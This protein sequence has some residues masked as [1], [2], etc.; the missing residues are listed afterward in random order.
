M[1]CPS[2]R[3]II[4]QGEDA[5]FPERTAQTLWVKCSNAVCCYS[6]N[7]RII[8]PVLKPASTCH[9][10]RRQGLSQTDAGVDIIAFVPQRLTPYQ[11]VHYRNHVTLGVRTMPYDRHAISGETM[12]PFTFGTGDFPPKSFGCDEI[13]VFQKFLNVAFQHWKMRDYSM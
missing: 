2:I 7:M 9:P 3:H 4:L 1:S 13:V 10:A 12:K 8:S 5:A 6:T 11:S